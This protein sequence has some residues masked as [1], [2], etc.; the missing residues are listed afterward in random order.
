MI[1]FHSHILPQVDDGSQSP[2]QTLAML[3][4]AYDQG[5]R[6]MVATPHFYADAMIPETFLEK[7]AKAAA[8]LPQGEGLPQVI[9][10]AETAYFDHMSRSDAIRQ[11][12]IQGTDLLLVE[13]PFSAWTDRI[14]EDVCMLTDR[15]GLTPVLAHVE[16]YRQRDQFLKYWQELLSAG[17][18]FQY[19]AGSFLR[20]SQ[21]GWVLKQLKNGLVHFLGSDCH[22]TTTRPPNMGQA[23]ELIQKK[24]LEPAL[25]EIRA[26]SA[27]V[28]HL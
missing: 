22:N 9:L 19:N 3:Q 21:R 17:V 7:R 16:R 1:D 26:F 18:L 10:G 2:E 25:D 14:V 5:V 8:Q 24:K 12:R 15:Q 20:G 6:Y 23:V 28:L 27:E 11:M 13:M 4:A